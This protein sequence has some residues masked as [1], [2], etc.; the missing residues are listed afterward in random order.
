[1]LAPTLPLRVVRTGPA[2]ADD[3]RVRRLPLFP[4]LAALGE[5]AGRAARVPAAG[6]AALAAAHRVADRVHRG[7]AV[8]RLAAHVPLA[9]RLAEADVHV[10]GVADAADGRPALR[11]D[12][13]HFPRRQRDLCPLALAG[14][15]GGAGAGAAAE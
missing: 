1:K 11:A 14:R 7:A 13:A 4:R 3:G 12:A 8:V 15:Q 5:H 10:L 9:A 6:G 2:A